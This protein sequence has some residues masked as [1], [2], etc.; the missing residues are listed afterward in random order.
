MPLRH[1][2]IGFAMVAAMPSVFASAQAGDGLYVP[3]FTYR[4]GP[5]AGSGTPYANGLTDYLNPSSPSDPVS[6]T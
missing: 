3:F 6:E 4:T 1:L 5:F 2:A